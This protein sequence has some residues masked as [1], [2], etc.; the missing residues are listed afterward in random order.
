MKF[1]DAV[2]LAKK[3]LVGIVIGLV[4]LVILSG[5]LWITQKSFTKNLKKTV[6]P[7]AEASRAN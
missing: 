1:S 7:T 4:P 5:G 3:I 2:L 6:T